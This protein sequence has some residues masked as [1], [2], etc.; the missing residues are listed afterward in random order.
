MK[1][2]PIEKV[3]EAWTAVVDDRVK[4]ED[5]SDKDAGKAV[6]ESSDGVKT[7]TVTWRDGGKIFASTEPAT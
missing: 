7:Y 3:P 5:G 1:E 6:V 2:T 4:I